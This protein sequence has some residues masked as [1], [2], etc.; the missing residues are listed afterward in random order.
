MLISVNPNPSLP[1]FQALMKKT[2]VLLNA[3]ALM[4]KKGY[5]KFEILEFE[6]ERVPRY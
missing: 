2:D 5:D 3:D 4:H 1:E 6:D